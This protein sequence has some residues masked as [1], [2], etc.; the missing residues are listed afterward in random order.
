M[1]FKSLWKLAHFSHE[2]FQPYRTMSNNKFKSF[3]SKE[4]FQHWWLVLK[5]TFSSFS[6]DKGIKLSA[7]LAYTTVF[8]IGPLL[9][10]IMSL[11]SIFYGAEATQGKIFKELHGLIGAD[12]AKQIQ[13]IIKNIEFS[14]KTKFALIS[15]IVTLIIGAT[16]LFAEIQDS[17]N[18]IW[19][20]KAKP[21][22]GWL[23]FLK[24]RLISSSLI[25]SLGFL[26][27]VSLVV[28]GAVDALS[29]VLARYLSFLGVVLIYIIN[30]AITFSVL[31]VLFAI[32]FK[33]LPD[34]KIKWKDVR[35][36]AIFTTILFF[37]GRFLIGLY[38]AKTGTASTYGAAGSII[39]ILVWIYYS[40]AI[41]YLGAEFTQV[42]SELYG[43]K[44]IPAEYAVH[45]EQKEVERDVN[46]LP[47]QHPELKEKVKEL[48]Q[49]EKAKEE[50]GS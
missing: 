27:I 31:T 2:M 8:S 30:F 3:F 17:L 5:T 13:D 42:Y 34:A 20:I 21:K 32:I 28:N 26:L 25:V 7:S 29:D 40:S 15:S 36:G 23:Q 35:T 22:L 41:L 9:L 11:A 33:V 24:N 39:V 18:M 6:D 37:I 46:K 44:I 48:K 38:I 1:K 43:G 4:N 10:L 49:Q 16:S 12:A 19:K 14:G 50:V 45:V 47:A